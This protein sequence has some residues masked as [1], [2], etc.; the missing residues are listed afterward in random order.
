LP[1]ASEMPHGGFKESG[2]GKD[3]SRYSFEEYTTAKHI[4]FELDGAAKKPWHAAVF[5]DPE[6]E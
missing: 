3:M 1:I 6:S 5:Y 2:F 4:M